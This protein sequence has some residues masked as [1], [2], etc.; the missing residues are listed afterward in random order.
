MFKVK[1]LFIPNIFIPYLFWLQIN[2]SLELYT[3]VILVRSGNNMQYYVCQSGLNPC[4]EFK[5]SPFLMT[6]A[7]SINEIKWVIR[8]YY[9]FP[10]N[11][12]SMHIYTHSNILMTSS[13]AKQ[14]NC[15]NILILSKFR[16]ILLFSAFWFQLWFEQKRHGAAD[17]AN[18][19]V[20]NSANTKTCITTTASA[21]Y[22]YKNKLPIHKKI[23][24]KY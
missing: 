7:R 15:Q 17:Q 18:T 19:K 6:V 14:I 8:Q 24:S 16:N 13:R 21:H 22:Y 5:H 10:P 12:T 9:S 2:K 11:F 3:D 1:V 20:F 4:R 23:G